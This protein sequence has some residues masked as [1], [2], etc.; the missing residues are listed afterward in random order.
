M[1]HGLAKHRS[2]F[3]AGLVAVLILTLVSAFVF[4]DGTWVDLPLMILAGIFCALLA[5]SYSEKSG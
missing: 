3:T 1:A 5:L 2:K 4:R